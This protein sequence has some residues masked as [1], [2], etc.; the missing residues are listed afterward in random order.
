MHSMYGKFLKRFWAA[1][2]ILLL[3]AAGLV[4]VFDPFFHYHKPIASLK[5]VLTKKEYQV[6]GTLK[7]FD[8]DSLIVGSSTAENFNN[9]W[10]DEAFG[11]ISV[12]AIKSSGVTA[13]LD[14]YIRLA[15]EEQKLK[16][17]FYSLDLFALSGD[18]DTTF[19]DE[20]MPLYLYDS[21][22]FTDVK[23]LL[24]KDVIFEDIPY[25]IAE[26]FLE[27][28]DEGASYN[29]AQYHTFSRSEA[30]DN[31][32]RPE[33][34]AQEKTEEE[35]RPDIDGNV[36]ILEKMVRE[37]PDTIFYIFYPPYSLL[38]WDNMIRSGQLDQSLYAAEASMERLLPYENVKLYYFQNE[39]DVILDLDLYMDPIHFSEDINH[40]MVEE[41]AQDQYRITLEDYR[42]ELEKMEQIVERIRRDYDGLTAE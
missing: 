16:Y 25:M 22:P 14:Y 8:Y 30:L 41:M 2:V 13:Q 7:N 37:D 18:P 10:F 20:S 34:T 17:V 31:Y 12:K 33:G 29:W 35:Y 4:F 24:N 5:E 6:P 26:S 28:Y 23:Y 40:W 27:D 39:E 11:A 38:W 32:N 3:L 21:N 9:R 15:A 42:Q 19:P 1:V 36:D